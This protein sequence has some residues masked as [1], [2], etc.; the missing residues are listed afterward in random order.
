MITR[1]SEDGVLS[2]AMRGEL[3]ADEPDTQPP[4]DDEIIINTGGGSGGAK[5]V[6]FSTTLAQSSVSTRSIAAPGI[7]S[8]MVLLSIELSDPA[9]QGS[10]WVVTPRDG[11]IEL[12]GT[13]AKS[14]VVVFIFGESNTTNAQSII[15]MKSAGVPSDLFITREVSNSNVSVTANNFHNVAIKIPE[16]DG[17]TPIAVS[18]FRSSSS[19]LCF[20]GVTIES[21]G[22]HPRLRNTTSSNVSGATVYITVL[23]VKE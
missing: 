4:E 15:P 23:Y 6:R 10:R 22:V 11:S 7:T 2:L 12:D 20:Y 5:I 9:V 17:Y 18:G 14:G 13:I 8:S 19:Y 3:W 1:Y 16:V 21:D